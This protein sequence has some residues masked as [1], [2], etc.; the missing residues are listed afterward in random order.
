MFL[1]ILILLII[2]IAAQHAFFLE[3]NLT[4]DWVC[5][6]PKHVFATLHIR[7]ST[8]VCGELDLVGHGG[9]GSIITCYGRVL[10]E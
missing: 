2:G 1:D 9:S 7:W 5:I 6:C 10:V 4:K 3:E 8:L